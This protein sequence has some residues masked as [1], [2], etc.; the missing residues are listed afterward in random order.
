MLRYGLNSI[1]IPTP[2]ELPL[3][4]SVIMKHILLILLLVGLFGQRVSAI[5]YLRDIQPIFAEHCTQ[6]HGVDEKTRSSEYRLDVETIARRGGA[7]GKP[8]IVAGK[9]EESE[10]MSRILAT[11]ADVVMP[12]PEHQRPLTPKQIETIRQWIQQGAPFASHWA[13]TTPKQEPLP[14]ATDNPIDA[15]VTVRLASEGLQLAPQAPSSVLCR[16]IYLDL[17]G[18]PPS[19]QQLAAFE[20]QGIEATIDQLLASERFGEKWARHWLD[21]ARYSDTNGYEKDLKREQWKWRDWVIDALNRDM[22][23]DQFIVE[24]IA[25]D[26]LPNATQ[27][28]IIATGFLRNSMINEEGAIVPEQFRMTEMFDRMDCIGKSILGLSTQCAQCHSHKF[29]PLTQRE[30]YGMFAYLNNAYESQSWIHSD[31]QLQLIREI[32]TK[33]AEQE[34]AARNT[35]PG[36]KDELAKWEQQIREQADGTQWQPVRMIE[37]GSISGLNHPT[38]EAD[39]SILMK[40]HT[41]ADV[42][43]ISQD[44]LQ[45]VTGVRLELLNHRDLPFNGPGRS[46]QG[47]WVAQEFEVLTNAPG[48]NDWV[49][50]KLVQPSADFSEPESKDAEGKNGTGPVSFLIDGKDEF[51]WKADRGIGR[52]NQPSVAVIQFESPLD[53]PENTKIKFVLRMGDMI[54]C[55]RISLTTSPSPAALPLDYAALQSI[56]TPSELRTEEQQRTIFSAWR[57]TRPELKSVNETID[58][59]VKQLPS[60][61]T[62]ILHL[63]EREPQNQRVTFLLERGAWDRPAQPVEPH[64]PGALHPFPEGAPNNRLGFAKWLTSPQS[65][66]TARV[67]VNRI[68]Q[69]I[70]GAGLVE[71]AE[72]FGTRAPLPVYRELLDWLAVDLQNHQWSQKRLIRQILTSRTYQQS[73]FVDPKL[74]ERDP[75]NALLAR[76]PRFRADAEVIRDVALT[77]SGLIHHR[78]GGP[79]VIPPVP[80]NV[81]DYNYVYPDYWK[82]AEG[83]DRYRRTVYGFRK[84]SMPDPA[85]SSL[86]APNADLPCVRRGRS[87]SPLAALTVLNET[88]FVE[89]AR[90]MAVR[91]LRE[92]GENEQERIEYAYLLCTGRKPS[93][94]ARAEIQS[95]LTKQRKRLAEGWMNAKEV[96]TGDASTMPA[97]PKN[98]TP[99]D[100]AAWTLVSRVL[101][102]LDETLS[103]N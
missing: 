36:W 81:L 86:D 100:M 59:L 87:N 82:P 101:L 102:N 22:P 92:A 98:N 32:N 5:D 70:F 55:C 40:G 67:A 96:A 71:T 23:Y 74:L 28:E 14:N 18:L 73:S 43:F 61:S 29:D 16:R 37:M 33:I 15:F 24:Q 30:Y 95:L 58:G 51:K 68:W 56:L 69:A 42:F 20:A 4:C 38:Q 85:M 25:G 93:E 17:I 27:S 72:D 3:P 48:S 54:G 12:P 65:P 46:S 78:L 10:L 6:C 66:L 8:A 60:A 13:F 35:I 21:A 83:P 103:K 2:T 41:S 94:A 90:A 75:K 19:P 80:Q 91:V 1:R 89:A 53:F 57:T 76:G 47:T 49:K 97:L 99:Q 39:Q 63:R 26:L 88:I 50:Q 79:S 84:R 62:S 64:V 45:G 52:R 11:D 44:R 9:P 7:S 31:E 77:A 34:Q